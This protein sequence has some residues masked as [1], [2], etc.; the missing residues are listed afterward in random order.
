MLLLEYFFVFVGFFAVGEFGKGKFALLT[1]GGFVE[2]G[3]DVVVDLALVDAVFE[4]HVFVEQELVEDRD[5]GRLL[6]L[7]ELQWE[8]KFGRVWGFLGRV[9]WFFGGF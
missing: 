3:E 2:A 6:F 7:L 1:D 8:A 4:K 9:F 5:L